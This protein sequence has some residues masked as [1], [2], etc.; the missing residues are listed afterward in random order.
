MIIIKKILFLLLPLL[1]FGCTPYRQSVY[2]RYDRILDQI[3][4]TGGFHEFRIQPKDELAIV[5][6]TTDPAASVPFYRKIGQDAETGQTVQGLGDV[7]L[8]N[9]IVD[10][11]GNID[12]PVLGRFRVSGLTAQECE[13]L[14]RQ[15]LAAYL[16]EEPNVT[17]RIANFKISV[18]GEVARPGTYSVSDEGINL[19]QALALAGDMTLF[20]ERDDVQLLRQDATGHY[21]VIHLDMTESGITLSSYYQLQQNDVIYVKPTRAKVRSHTF[22]NN[23]SM[24][25]SLTSILA[26][27]ASLVIVTF[28]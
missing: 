28:H 11:E 23:A 5:V 14:M 27:L 4:Q 1:F 3:E 8:F 9:Y 10:A 21:R 20:A 12:Y 19:F 24:W 17:V 22:S 7:K 25:I 6:S 18:L 16:N 26:T 13:A 15:K 2:L